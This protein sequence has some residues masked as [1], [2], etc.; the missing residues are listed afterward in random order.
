VT[1]VVS[2]PDGPLRF[3]AEPRI[4]GNT[5]VL[6]GLHAFGDTARSYLTV[7]ARAPERVEEALRLD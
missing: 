3:V 6:I 5:Q 7:I 2:T 4:E 1:A